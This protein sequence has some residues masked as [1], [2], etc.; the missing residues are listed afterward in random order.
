MM[1]I[2]ITKI[3]NSELGLDGTIT[4]LID[5]C[6]RYSD[7]YTDAALDEISAQAKQLGLPE[8]QVQIPVLV[9]LDRQRSQKD[10]GTLPY[11]QMKFDRLKGG[12]IGYSSTEEYGEVEIRQE[13]DKVLVTITGSDDNGFFTAASACSVEE[14]MTG[15]ENFLESFIGSVL[16]YSKV[17]DEEVS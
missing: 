8:D 9:K 14:F 3:Y 17:Y 2:S 6:Y 1:D 12:S 16:F 13:D 5:W 7:D 15:D 10:D 11:E 4:E